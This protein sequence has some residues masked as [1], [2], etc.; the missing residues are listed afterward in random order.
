MWSRSRV[1]SRKL[2]AKPRH[3]I[4]AVNA[5]TGRVIDRFDPHSGCAQGG[6]AIALSTRLAFVGGDGCLIGAFALTTGRQLWAIPRH[7]PTATTAAIVAYGQRVY[8]GGSFGSVEGSPSNGFA[9]L[10]QQSGKPLHTWHPPAGS[11][12]EALSISGHDL[13]IGAL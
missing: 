12:L 1:A 4:A 10:D 13:L 3:G 8:L 6:H 2:G 7:D 9:A 5:E 11:Q